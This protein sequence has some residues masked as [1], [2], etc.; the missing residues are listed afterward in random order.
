MI[1]GRSVIGLTGHGRVD[2]LIGRTVHE[3]IDAVLGLI[4]P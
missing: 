3:P 4:D 1:G 2:S